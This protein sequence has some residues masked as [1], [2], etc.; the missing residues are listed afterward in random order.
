ML[1]IKQINYADYIEKCIAGK[2]CTVR[3]KSHAR[4]YF[5]LS[6]SSGNKV[7][8]SF[9]GIQFSELQSELTFAQCVKKNALIVASLQ[10]CVQQQACDIY[11]KS[12]TNV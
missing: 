9:E 6:P 12:N 4:C 3:Y 8:I 1:C 2:K 10:Y 11:N 7:I 5:H